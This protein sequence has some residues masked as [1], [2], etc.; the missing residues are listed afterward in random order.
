[1]HDGKPGVVDGAGEGETSVEQQVGCD[2]T[3]RRAPYLW[4]STRS[5]YPVLGD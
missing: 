5:S 4:S 1:M 2:C 3:K